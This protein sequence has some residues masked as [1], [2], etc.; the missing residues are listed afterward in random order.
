MLH[1]G[2]NLG[3]FELLV[4]TANKTE[5]CFYFNK[6][7]TKESHFLNTSFI[8]FWINVKSA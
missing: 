4:S 7:E 2:N 6:N 8:T 1:L 5:Q 3:I